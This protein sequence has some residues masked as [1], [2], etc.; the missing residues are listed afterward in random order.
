MVSTFPQTLIRMGKTRIKKPKEYYRLYEGKTTKTKDKYNA[1]LEEIKEAADMD[2]ESRIQEFQILYTD[3]VGKSEEKMSSDEVFDFS[4]IL[5]PFCLVKT[6]FSICIFV[7]RNK[8][9]RFE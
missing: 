4:G 7:L 6:S 8:T 5:L 2:K 9:F 1:A 3:C